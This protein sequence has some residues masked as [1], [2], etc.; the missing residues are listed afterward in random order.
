MTDLKS[1]TVKLTDDDWDEIG[2]AA[3]DMGFGERG[4][5]RAMVKLAKD[6]N[7]KS[8]QEQA[9]RDGS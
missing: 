4:R 8:E 9:A 2:K 3:V 7:L 5:G 1:R 6:Q